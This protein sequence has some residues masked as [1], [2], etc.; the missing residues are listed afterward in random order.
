MGWLRAAEAIDALGVRPQ[1]LYANVSRKRIRAKPDPQ[2]PRR[3]VY[4]EGDVRSLARKRRGPRRVEEV[5]AGAIEWGDPILPSALSTVAGGRLWYR[6]EDAVALAQSRTLEDV[7]ALLW[8]SDAGISLGRRPKAG[9]S[10]GSGRAGVRRTVRA[11][12]AA[13]LEQAFLA[14]AARASQDPPSHGR[15]TSVLQVEAADVFATLADA[16][17]GPSREVSL[18]DRLASTWGRR[19]ASDILRRALVLL[20]DHELNAST[21]AARVT[22]STG[23]SLSA[24]VLAGLATLTGPLHGRAAAGLREL[25]DSA[26][27]QGAE[28]A[29]REWLA[30][31]RPI[32]GFGHPLYP[33]GDPRAVSLLQRFTLPPECA[34][35]RD[36]VEQW[37]G[38]RPNIDFAL[39]ALTKAHRLPEEAPLILFALSRCVGWLAHALEQVAMGHLIR[40]RAR[41]VGPKPHSLT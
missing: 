40:P 39:A 15:V 17:L 3:S 36:A 14:V 5:A 19:D 38:E 34:A 13:P 32:A 30:Q 23:A 12:G 21:F 9:T 6:G 27:A 2:D 20:A 11:P 29:V 22:I 7:A 10:R 8:G 37:V 31:G 25:M 41:Y 4:H 18:H 1:T 35:V 28:A 33:G 16:M 26:L 24:G